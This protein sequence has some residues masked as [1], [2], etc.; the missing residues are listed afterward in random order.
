MIRQSN[1]FKNIKQTNTALY[2][3]ARLEIADIFAKEL[4]PLSAIENLRKHYCNL[5]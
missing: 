1:H 3:K 2:T 4:N 5:T